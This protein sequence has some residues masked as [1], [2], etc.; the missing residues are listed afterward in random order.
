MVLIL[1]SAALGPPQKK[2]RKKTVRSDELQAI[3]I[4]VCLKANIVFLKSSGGM[5][6]F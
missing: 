6:F 2:K 4:L 1:P 5:I 3:W